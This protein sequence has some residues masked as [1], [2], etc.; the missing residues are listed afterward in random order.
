MKPSTLM[1]TGTIGVIAS[2][3]CCFTPLL[4]LLFGAI[5]LVAWVGYLDY[6]LMPALL[7]F[8]GLIIYA[9]TCESK[10]S[11]K[12]ELIYDKDC[13]NMEKARR[14][15]HTAL[16]RTGLPQIWKEWDRND[17]SS[18]IH[19]KNFGSPT[20]LVDGRDVA[21]ASETEGNNCRVYLYGL[22][23]IQGVP[24]V[25]QIVSALER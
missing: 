23:S 22:N 19:A 5:G 14:N 24:P 9:A 25:E 13:P 21:G 15:I 10:A 7:F 1:K 3:L 4:A 2:A 12:I 6:V 16:I 20:V 17:P 11:R 18:P 8:V